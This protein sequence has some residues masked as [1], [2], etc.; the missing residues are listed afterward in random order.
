M[1]FFIPPLTEFVFTVY[2]TVDCSIKSQ[3]K[4]DLIALDDDEKHLELAECT[5]KIKCRKG[6]VDLGDFFGGRESLLSINYPVV[7]CGV[8]F[9][10][11]F[12]DVVLHEAVN[13]DFHNFFE[14]LQPSLEASVSDAVLGI[15]NRIL[16]AFTYKQLFP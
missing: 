8:G 13:E 4:S 10:E 16:S 15:G 6:S 2:F 14:H 5:S 1:N 3:F 7:F 11:C 12:L 9:N